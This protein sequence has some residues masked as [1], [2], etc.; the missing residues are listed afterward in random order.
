MKTF[1]SRLMYK[2]IVYVNIIFNLLVVPLVPLCTTMH[3]FYVCINVYFLL[4]FFILAKY[5]SLSNNVN[6]SERKSTLNFI[7]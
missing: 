6:T 4:L 2:I 7:V 3:K 5:Y 1:K